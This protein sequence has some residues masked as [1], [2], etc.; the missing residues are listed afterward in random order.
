MSKRKR[1]EGK[2]DYFDNGTIENLDSALNIFENDVT[3]LLSFLED[4]KW[5]P[6]IQAWSYYSQTSNHQ[7]MAL[8]TSKIAWMLECCDKNISLIQYASIVVRDILENQLKIIYRC[9]HMARSNLTI[10]ILKLLK[11]IAGFHK[12]ALCTDLYSSFDLSMKALPKLLTVKELRPVFLRFYLTFMK[13]G[14]SLVKKDLVAQRKIIGPWFKEI[15]NDSDE[16]V[17]ETLKVL[18]DQIVLDPSFTKTS[19][20]SFFNDWMMGCL[21]KLFNKSNNEVVSILSELMHML[22]TDSERGVKFQDKGW[23]ATQVQNNKLLVN[24]LRMLKPWDDV[25]QQ[26]L[27]VNIMQ[28]SPELVAAYNAA[29]TDSIS[30]DPKLSS[31]WISYGTFYSR[32]LRLDVPKLDILAP[33]GEVVVENILPSVLSKSAMSKSLTNTSPMI[34]YFAAQIL[35]QS[36]TKLEEVFKI[37]QQNKWDIS[38]VLSGVGSRLPEVQAL[39]ECLNTLQSNSSGEFSLMKTVMMK[40]VALFCKLFPEALLT[41][42]LNLPT[43]FLE[44]LQNAE[45][46][47]GLKLIQARSTL[48][49]QARISKVGKW[50]NKIN[51]KYSTFTNLLRLGAI[52]KPLSDQVCDL[53]IDLTRPTLLFQLETLA[54][55]VYALMRSLKD[56]IGSMDS[57]QQEQIWN[58]IDES[59]ARCMRSPYKYVDEFASL[60]IQ[61]VLSPFI[62][63]L[64]E[65]FKYVKQPCKGVEKWVGLYLEY[66]RVIGEAEFKVDGVKL[67]GVNG[68]EMLLSN[69]NDIITTEL[70]LCAAKQMLLLSDDKFGIL[71]RVDSKQLSDA[72]TS[73]AFFT[74]LLKLPYSRYY[75]QTVRKIAAPCDFKELKNELD[76]IDNDEIRCDGLWMGIELINNNTTNGHVFAKLIEQMTGNGKVVDFSSIQQLSKLKYNRDEAVAAVEAN[77]AAHAAQLE[78]ADILAVSQL[79]IELGNEDLLCSLIQSTGKFDNESGGKVASLSVAAA[80]AKYTDYKDDEFFNKHVA[81][82]INNLNDKNSLVVLSKALDEGIK[83]DVSKIGEFM[84]SVDGQLAVSTELVNL[85]VKVVNSNSNNDGSIWVR[86]VCNWLSTRSTITKTVREF[87]SVFAL[88]IS[89]VDIWKIVPGDEVNAMVMN[90]MSMLVFSPETIKLATNLAFI[91]YG[92]PLNHSSLLDALLNQPGGEEEEKEKMSATLALLIWKLYMLDPKSHSTEKI[93]D[94]VLVKCR[95]STAAQDVILLDIVKRIEARLNT[96]WVNRVF[97]WTFVNDSTAKLFTQM[98]EGISVNVDMQTIKQSVKRFNTSTL[99]LEPSMSISQCEN[100][101]DEYTTLLPPYGTTVSYDAE[102]LLMSLTSSPEL[103]KDNGVID[104]KLFVESGS[105]AF[106]I[107]CFAHPVLSQAAR[108]IIS[109]VWCYFTQ[110]YEHVLT[111]DNNNNNEEE[112]VHAITYRERLTVRTLL[113]KLQP[114]VGVDDDNNNN[115]TPCIYTIIAQL[116]PV[117]TNPGH[118]MYPRAIDWLLS[119]PGILDDLPMYKQIS[120]NSPVEQDDA[121]LHSRQVVWLIEAFADC[122]LTPQGLQLML[123]RGVVEWVLTLSNSLYSSSHLKNK[124]KYL[125]ARLQETPHGAVALTTRHAGL[126]WCERRGD[127]KLQL[128]MV[129]AGSKE[130]IGEWVGDSGSDDAVN[131]LIRRT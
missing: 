9:L 59:V 110:H 120:S 118:F 32:V 114:S 43:E 95:G 74:G 62:I 124:V 23:Y 4:N 14:S 1:D 96:S 130:R 47:S 18:K 88:F 20:I 86:K 77:V 122:C 105:L 17:L 119:G 28:A 2:E 76:Q 123:K 97:T 35:V 68:M 38:S 101:V 102:F 98:D 27:A 127:K 50:Y 52:N 48:T 31:F 49:V 16:I 104:I 103:F 29:V 41:S 42:K 3:P 22:C 83:I 94:K 63:T 72:I 111:N 92:K 44:D 54:H 87:A 40:L 37:Y 126:S 115:L 21:I 65:Q 64:G 56:S 30:F 71:D 131:S 55:P 80:V 91:S 93:Q 34:R 107:A 112:N 85:A 128:R 25:E 11:A 81:T 6:L 26:N 113:A 53:I 73:K 13:N 46:L 69:N 51:G 78:T 33:V 121:H 89:R 15:A 58:L 61:G 5:K 117:L 7:K 8:Y 108:T 67:K 45:G 84:D 79:L 36:L 82:A 19:K 12:G 129:F 116:I 60:G 100:A 99:S 70:E 57:T 39:S 66:S 109:T 10:P 24:V 90:C 125:I 106:V 75:L